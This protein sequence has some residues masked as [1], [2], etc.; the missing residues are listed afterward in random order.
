MNSRIA[1]IHRQ[2]AELLREL[3]DATQREHLDALRPHLD[4]SGSVEVPLE[5]QCRAAVVLAQHGLWR[6]PARVYFIREGRDGPIKIGYSVDVAVRLST[7]QSSSSRTLVLLGVVPGGAE[8]ERQLHDRFAGERIRG[9]WFEASVAL[10][11]FIEAVVPR[12]GA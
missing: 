11:Q 4:P 3:A 9:E 10:L 6:G 1:Q 8:R 12:E 5:D 7:L 2:I